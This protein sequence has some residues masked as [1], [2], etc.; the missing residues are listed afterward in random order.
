MNELLTIVRNDL[1]LIFR[2]KSLYVIFVVPLAM[3]LIF[4]VGVPLLTQY[5]PD[6][7]D[8]VWLIVA[9]FTA[10]TAA[11]PSYLIGFL[12]LDEQDENVHLLQRILPLPPFFILKSRIVLTILI[13]FFFSLLLLKFNSLISFSFVWCIATSLLFSLI[14]PILIFCIVAFS[15]NKIEAATLY[16]GLSVLLVLPAIAFFIS[17]QWKYVFSPIPFF[18][19]YNAFQFKGI[20]PG[21]FLNLLFGILINM[22]FVCLLFKVY[23]KRVN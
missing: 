18:W 3:L 5:V 23:L 21:Y 15:K 22:G 8:Y 1:K 17:P 20:G 6:A 19:I 16:K 7:N 13:S 11:T 14:P 9:A 12:L 10:V 2:D 4:W